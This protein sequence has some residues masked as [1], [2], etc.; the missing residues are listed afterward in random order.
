MSYRWL[1]S[2][3]TLIVIGWSVEAPAESL[4]PS[5]YV[6]TG[7]NATLTIDVLPLGAEVRLDGVR[8]GTAQ[9]LIARAL[10]VI[11]G[12]HVVQVSAQG[13]LTNLVQVVGT[14]NWSTRVQIH[15]VPDRH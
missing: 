12:Y 5:M 2:A 10:P 4:N 1:L 3:V 15:L 7:D 9:D 8:L 11:P 14:P 13:H 6:V